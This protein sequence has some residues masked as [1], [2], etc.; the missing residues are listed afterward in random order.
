MNDSD[1]TFSALRCCMQ[2]SPAVVD[3]Q[4]PVFEWLGLFDLPDTEGYSIRLQLSSDPDFSDRGLVRSL[5]KCCSASDVPRI[6]AAEWGGERVLEWGRVYYWRLALEDDGGEPSTW[7]AVQVVLTGL[8]GGRWPGQWVRG[9]AAQDR[10]ENR[11]DSLVAQWAGAATA[12]SGTATALRGQ[13][14]VWSFRNEFG[15]PDEADS[16]CLLFLA[17]CGAARMRINGRLVEDAVLDPVQTE[18]DKEQSYR[19]LDV[20]GFVRAGVN[21]LEVELAGGWY[22]QPAIWPGIAD[23]GRPSFSGFLR[24]GGATI[25]FAAGWSVLP[26]S[27]H[28]ANLYA[29]ECCDGVC[30]SRRQW[31][32][33]LQVKDGRVAVPVPPPEVPLRAQE[34]PSATPVESFPPASVVRRADGSVCVDLGRNIAG[35]LRI[36]PGEQAGAVLVLEYAEQL[37]GDGS[38][39]RHTIGEFATKVGQVDLYR[40]AGMEG[41][42]WRADWGYKAFRYVIIQGWTGPLERERFEAVVVRNPLAKIGEFRS[43][44]ELLNRLQTLAYRSMESNLHGI[45]EDCPG[46]EKCGWLGDM[47]ATHRV[48]WLNFDLA[49]MMLKFV[50]DIE[51][52]TE[53]DGVAPGIVG[54]AR[55]C[56]KW[57]DWA[58]ATVILPCQAYRE[59]GD[60]EA[61][62]AHWPYV[63]RYAETAFDRL[64][65]RCREGRPIL[66][67]GDWHD[68][69]LGDWCDLPADR[70]RAGE[71]FPSCSDPLQIACM[72][73]FEAL[74]D[75][76]NIAVW[77]GLDR[78]HPQLAAKAHAVAERLRDLY[79][80]PDGSYGSQTGDALALA[81]GLSRQPEKTLASLL[82]RLE[83]NGGH[84]DVGCYGHARLWSVLARH[85]HAET[86]LDVLTRP[87]YPGFVDQIARGATTLWERQGEARKEGDLPQNSLNHHFHAGYGSFLYEYCAG[88]R[89]SDE[90]IAWSTIEFELPLL[91]R[92]NSAEASVQTVRGRGSSAWQKT[93]G[94]VFWTVSI[95]P[96]AVAAIH[97]PC[98]RGAKLTA[99]VLPKKHPALDALLEESVAG[100]SA[101]LQ[102]G[103]HRFEW[104]DDA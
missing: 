55:K 51:L 2:T 90:S 74:Q 24:Q 102:A 61:L 5:R 84:F 78:T 67:P 29:G 21:E 49:A 86:A 85:G 14:P 45:F 58:A 16:P 35:M 31:D 93:N 97:F 89:Q 65:E 87:G 82:R 66:A 70:A 54:G 11:V 103:T 43:D 96:G 12:D 92:L 37:L 30:S 88:M 34:I 3:S 94:K 57:M 32:G 52:A 73:V 79:E 44:S 80:D 69:G 48:W 101:R 13:E 9:S 47:L 53:E 72:T 1:M 8:L 104:Y 10:L 26:S 15:L 60:S 63:V 83:M 75:S 64:M 56:G 71:E 42:N 100:L 99:S 41:E 28:G 62:A 38:P 59:R 27:T 40:C 6:T 68:F 81:L 39:D 19:V 4:F 95:P 36:R 23:Y 91:R 22:H 33:A 20:S 98:G 46:R 17:A 7:S 18:Y 77:L 76:V 25:P 50:R